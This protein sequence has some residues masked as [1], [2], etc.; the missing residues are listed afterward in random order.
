MISCKVIEIICDG[1]NRIGLGH[2]KRSMALAKKAREQGFQV[3]LTALSRFAQDF[4]GV[5]PYSPGDS[6]IRLVDLPVNSLSLLKDGA[7]K[8]IKT[9]TLDA[10]FDINQ[11]INVVIYPHADI[12]RS[13]SMYVGYEYVILRDEFLRY[14][15]NSADARIEDD[16]VF[17][18]VGGSDIQHH[19]V[20]AMEM[21][22]EL[23]IKVK[24]VRGTP[25]DSIK[26]NPLSEIYVNPP[27]IPEL[28]YK[29]SWC[30]VSGGG[31]LFEAAYFKK[32]IVVVPQ[33][34]YEKNIAIDFLQ[35]KQVLGVGIESVPQLLSAGNIKS[36]KHDFGLID[37]MG[38][39]RIL[40]IIKNSI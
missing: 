30:I 23:G 14:S 19:G 12:V 7:S 24:L 9:I 6:V 17:I 1:G 2:L 39:D 21:L 11:D 26:P 15:D 22:N 20:F 37:G 31:S 13:P 8:D 36:N 10:L 18:M 16:Y 29:S 38:A 25:F 34:K 27:N 4:V 3:R 28:I 35:R 40:R 5:Q 32:P 33:S